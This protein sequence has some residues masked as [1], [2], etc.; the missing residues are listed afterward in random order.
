MY[1]EFH[2]SQTSPAQPNEDAAAR[3]A[4]GGLARN[5]NVIAGVVAFGLVVLA[6]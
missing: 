5:V 4:N 1:A 2:R 3:N 6:I